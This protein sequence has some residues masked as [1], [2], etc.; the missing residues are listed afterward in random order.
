MEL[1]ELV[2]AWAEFLRGQAE[3]VR[4]APWPLRAPATEEMITAA[5]TRLGVRLPPSY[6]AF[7]AV[8]DGIEAV[9]IDDELGSAPWA[10]GFLGTADLAWYRDVNPEMVEIWSASDHPEHDEHRQPAPNEGP[11]QDIFCPDC[12]PQTLAICPEDDYLGVLLL[13]PANRD[14]AGEWEFW[15]FA[16]NIPGALAW[17][18]FPDYL[19]WQVRGGHAAP[20]QTS[21]DTDTAAIRAAAD[22]DADD[23]DRRQAFH[24]LAT[25]HNT[26]RGLAV[27]IEICHHEPDPWLRARAMDQLGS[28]ASYRTDVAPDLVERAIDALVVALDAPRRPP[29][30]LTFD[31]ALHSLGSSDHPRAIAAL[32]ALLDGGAATAHTTSLWRGIRHHA[33]RYLPELRDLYAATGDPTYLCM[34]FDHD[35]EAATELREVALRRPDFQVP[36]DAD[37]EYDVEPVM[38]QVYGDEAAYVPS[39]WREVANVLEH[40]DSRASED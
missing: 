38:V 28:F 39:V 24:A 9:E 8:S 11:V 4:P 35:P 3:E 23:R 6:R 21:D 25:A 19:A 16:N 22:P 17:S 13:N 36:Y 1:P 7:L 31:S 10:P 5:E 27:L 20:P 26:E 33:D 14:A 2:A 15:E 32:R 34:L 12:F 30:H 18:S 40:A 37:A 29:Y